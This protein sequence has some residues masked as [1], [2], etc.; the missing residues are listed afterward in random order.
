MEKEIKKRKIRKIE[1]YTLKWEKLAN[2]LAR[3]WC[4]N[5]KPCRECGY[6]VVDGYCCDT[7]GSSMP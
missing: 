7:C 1:P 6:P 2:N 5:I 3:S 4:H